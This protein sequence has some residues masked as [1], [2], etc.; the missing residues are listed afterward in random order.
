M[1]LKHVTVI[2][3]H[4]NT[5]IINGAIYCIELMQKNNKTHKAV[6]RDLD[7]VKHILNLNKQ[8]KNA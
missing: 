5:H 6:V 2:M 4:T 8:N 3:P 7:I 1:Q